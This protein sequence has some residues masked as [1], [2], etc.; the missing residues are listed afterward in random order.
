M[1]KKLLLLSCVLITAL[2]WVI[3]I[4]VGVGGETDLRGNPQPCA[5]NIGDPHTMHFPQLPDEGSVAPY[6][7]PPPYGYAVNATAD[8]VLADDFLCTETGFITDIHFWGGW[9]GGMVGEI[10]Y[11]MLSIHENIPAD[12]NPD[13]YS[14]PGETLWE[15]EVPVTYV[16]VVQI[17]PPVAQ[18]WYDPSTGEV[19]DGDHSS[20]YQYNVC[21]EE[22]LSPADIFYQT[23]DSIYW[24]KINAVIVD[25]SSTKWGWKNSNELWMD[26]AV[27]GYWGG[28]NV[29][30][31]YDPGIPKVT[32][33][34]FIEFGPDGTPIDAGG[35]D[36][37]DDGTSI[38]GWFYYPN[39]DWWNIWFYD[40]PFEPDGY[41]LYDIY[42]E[43]Y[44]TDPYYWIE[45]SANW[46]TPDWPSGNPP[47]VPPLTP[48]EENLY[49]ER[50]YLELYPPGFQMFGVLIP[51]Y[52]PEWVSIDFMGQN[53]IIEGG[54]TVHECVSSGGA[55]SLDLAFVITG[56]PC[57]LIMG[58]A[59]YSGNIDINDVVYL[60]TYIFMGGPLPTP[61]ACASGDATCD[62]HVDIDDV[63][64]LINYIFSGGQPPCSS[65]D[66]IEAYC[67]QL[68]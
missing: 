43:W 25:P 41:K 12:Q 8:V 10:Q 62:C 51:D 7:P 38:N 18:S 27:W 42:F 17:D 1:T 22:F 60:I 59:D 66:W 48:A 33:T 31:I 68:R 50:E 19:I 28:F 21:L 4:T 35:T 3:V 40:H 46:T 55:P 37:Y 49:I 16:D 14:I 30:E 63:V 39:T 61:F 56:R 24:L 65:E 47:P 23:K 44:P 26:D 54:Y 11:F 36:Y 64:R 13:G 58:D 29:Y 5:W 32:N 6:E 20:Y 34:F 45:V 2:I 67:G 57:D 52:C 15:T 53:F 9:K